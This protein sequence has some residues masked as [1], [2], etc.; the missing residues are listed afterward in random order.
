MNKN[1]LL[2]IATLALVACGSDSAEIVERHGAERRG[3]AMELSEDQGL[4]RVL[5]VNHEEVPVVVNKLFRIHGSDAEVSFEFE[6]VASASRS[7][8]GR[9]QSH[10]PN[11]GDS[12]FVLMPRS[13]VGMYYLKED[14]QD[15]YSVGRGCFKVKAVYENKMRSIQADDEKV[16]SNE[17]SICFD[18]R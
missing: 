5:L 12:L 7:Y 8:G 10:V 2:L 4:V 9:G 18:G 14:I 17:V 6:A 13:M 15:L 1:K 16:T 11:P 3:L